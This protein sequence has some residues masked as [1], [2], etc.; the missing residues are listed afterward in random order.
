[1]HPSDPFVNMRLDSTMQDIVYKLLPQIESDE[2]KREKDYYESKGIPYPLRE[3]T[4][5]KSGKRKSKGGEGE[6]PQWL[7]VYLEY[8]GASPG[9]GKFKPLPRGYL[10][11]PSITTVE[12]IQTYITRT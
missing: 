1:M 8:A 10:R 12:N 5:S 6:F 2:K 3:T 7:S 11:I 4:P 9:L